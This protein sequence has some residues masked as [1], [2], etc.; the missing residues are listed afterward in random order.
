[1]EYTVVPEIAVA[2]IQPEA[3]LDQVCLLGCTVTTG[4]GAVL[5]ST[6]VRPGDCVAVFGLGGIGLSVVQGAVL[7]QAGRIIAVDID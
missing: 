5:N 3:A 7:A 4:V 2:R 1:S 6:H